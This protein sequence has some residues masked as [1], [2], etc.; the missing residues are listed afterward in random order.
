VV[1]VMV[2]LRHPRERTAPVLKWMLGSGA[3]MA[4]AAGGVVAVLALTRPGM[5]L[6][7]P[8]GAGL[9]QAARIALA[10]IALGVGVMPCLR[11]A[12]ASRDWFALQAGAVALIMMMFL[13]FPAARDARAR[14]RRAFDPHRSPLRTTAPR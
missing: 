8:A 6:P 11:R 1:A 4:A 10:T 9:D 14:I 7:P 3:M 5:V 13:V 12:L 2:L